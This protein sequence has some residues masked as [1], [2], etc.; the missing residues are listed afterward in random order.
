MPRVPTAHALKN[1]RFGRRLKH[2]ARLSYSHLL[3]SVGMEMQ[4]GGQT[5]HPSRPTAIVVSHEASATGAPILALNLVQ[6]LSQTHN[7]V[8]ML[9]KGGPLRQQ[10]Q[11]SGTALIKA[12]LAFVN[13]KLV[14]RALKTACKQGN[15]E[16]ALVN[17]VV[18]T[19]FLEPLRGEGITCLCLV[20]EFVTYI[21][22]LDIFSEI[23]RW[24]SRV[25]CSTPLT[26]RDVLGHC[27]HLAPMGVMNQQARLGMITR[28]LIIPIHQRLN[29]A[30]GGAGWIGF[31]GD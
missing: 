28:N 26:W 27:N 1:S 5:F 30:Q 12:R 31:V 2:L 4:A 22:P 9:L 19:P 29:A 13:R 16:F 14:K 8:V 20:H 7:V 10:F 11:A 17:S 6:Q 15:P 18:S 21:K 24:S 25:V 3:T 23:G